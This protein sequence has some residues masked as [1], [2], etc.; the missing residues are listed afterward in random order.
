MS[1]GLDLEYLPKA[2]RPPK[3]VPM[4]GV[5]LMGA[6]RL[7]GVASKGIVGPWS[8]AHFLSAKK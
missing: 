4:G 6:F 2:S 7:L 1:G 5:N 3:M 8:L